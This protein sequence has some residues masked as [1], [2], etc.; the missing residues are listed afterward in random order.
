MQ[1]VM[2]TSISD[3]AICGGAPAFKETLH[4]G[5]PNIG[6]R[7]QLLQRF[8]QILDNRWLTNNGPFVQEFEAKTAQL[9]G[10]KHC[11]AMCNAT[12]AVEE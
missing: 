2:K 6:D 5:R 12:I 11:I 7:K 10:V 9:L 8:N 4:V 1:S 3:L